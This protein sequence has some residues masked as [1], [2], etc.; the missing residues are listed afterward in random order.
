[1]HKY[2]LLLLYFFFPSVVWAQLI[3]PDGFFLQDSMKVGEEIPYV[4][5]VKYPDDQSIIF[6][7]TSYNYSPFELVRKDYSNTVSENGFSTDSVIYILRTFD[8][9][10]LQA[11][12]L[13][14]YIINKGDSVE[15]KA[16]QDTIYLNEIEIAPQEP[17]KE[18]TNY[19]EVAL[20]FNTT[21]LILGIII[22][23][24]ILVVVLLIYGDQIKRKIKLYKLRKRHEKFLS[25]F[26]TLINQ[27]N[28]ANPKSKAE[29][30]L[31]YWKSYMEKLEKIPFSKLTTKEVSQLIEDK[32]LLF[33]L[34]IMDRNIYGRH[35]SEEIQ[36]NLKSLE[37]IAN[38]RYEEKVEEV[39]NE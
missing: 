9:S 27:S 11:F 39:K 13:P 38:K 16:Q 2:K 3:S 15:V 12:Q 24:V 23:V 10:A 22:F 34:K 37:E 1:M 5:T 19:R 7:D 18:T 31:N 25:T 33:T 28:G 14:V 35:N 30:S 26:G 36:E 21:Y 6:P 32:N 4:L 8:L 29:T 20:Q 17:L